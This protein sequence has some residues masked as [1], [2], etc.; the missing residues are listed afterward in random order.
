MITS[1]SFEGMQLAMAN[2]GLP[3]SETLIADSK[4]RR[5]GIDGDKNKKPCWYILH[6]FPNG[7]VYGAF[8]CW[9]RGIYETWCNGGTKSLSNQEKILIKQKQEQLEK[10]RQ[11]LQIEAKENANYAWKRAQQ[12]LVE[13][14]Y[15]SC[16]QVKSYGL[17]SYKGALLIPLYNENNELCS[18]QFIT[19]DGTKRF[20]KNA[21]MKGCFFF[22]GNIST[23]ICISEGY[24]TGA[25]IHE[26]T[27]YGVVVALNAHNL[28]PVAQII[29]KKYPNVEIVVCAD[30]DLFSNA[31]IGIQQA[32]I[33]AKTVKAKLA[34]PQFKNIETQPTD[35]NDLMILEGLDEVKTQLSSATVPKET[36]DDA[37]L[38]LTKLTLPEYE[39][40]RKE[41]AHALKV[42]VR[43]LDDLVDK[44]RNSPLLDDVQGDELENGVE[45]WHESVIGEELAREI[46]ELFETHVILSEECI[47]ALT[48]WVFGSYCFDAFNIFP[49]LL[50]TSPIK[51]CGK[52]TVLKI[53]FCITHRALLA[54]NASAASIFRGVDLWKPTLLI[55]EGDSFIKNDEEL[56]GIINS[57]HSKETAYVLRVEGDSN[58]RTP[59]R[60]S[61]WSPM[62]IA[63]IKNPAD[64]ILDRSIVI[65]LRRKLS[66]EHV[67]RWGMN[68]YEKFKILRQKLK[69]WANDNF[70]ALKNSEP[71]IANI[72]ND[73]AA[74]NWVLLTAI[75]KLLGSEFLKKAEISMRKLIV[76]DDEE[77]I[78]VKL[79]CDIKS[80]FETMNISEIHSDILVSKLI[81]LADSFWAE[82]K[83][84]APITK[85]GLA[86]ILRSFG[87]KSKQLWINEQ[88]KNGYKLID[89]QDVFIRYIHPIETLKL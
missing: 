22:I 48:L 37:V 23:T 61:T 50:I 2:A 18:L 5:F 34:I 84:N 15:L 81:A 72:G 62:A 4:F 32:T 65:H 9:K 78:S 35:F 31:N 71:S 79:L 21:L 66:S 58:N 87:I 36:I 14:P 7:L 24:A 46:M 19:S 57:G 45:A 74:D 49:K 29:R 60:F 73:R 69:R 20:K 3:Y 28:L 52:S 30:N 67:T 12:N 13:H 56:R 1:D 26:A 68:N 44:K 33:T 88:N 82:Y 10:E 80:I 39:Q 70:M 86:K 76:I 42:R 6:I 11:K 40:V 59:K 64:T 54:S 89:F 8:G 27:G 55:D 63:M 25:T 16:K 85:N 53:L 75:A 41:E 38:R 51:R 17:R 77:C 47:I 83:N 43:F